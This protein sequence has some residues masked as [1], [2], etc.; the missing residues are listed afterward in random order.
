MRWVGRSVGG[1][2][3]STA[4]RT[5]PLVPSGV[6]RAVIRPPCSSQT[7]RAMARPRPVPPPESSPAP[8]RSKTRSTRSAGMPGPSSRTSSHQVDASAARPVTST[9]PPGGLCRTALST[10]FA[11]SWA[12]RAGSACTVRSVGCASCRTRTG[13]PS[14]EASATAPA[15]RSATRTSE[16][17]RGA[18]PASILDRSSRSVTRA[19]SRSDWCSAPRRAASSGRTTPSTRFSRRARWAASGVRSSCD[20]VATSWR[21]W[22]SAEARSAA[23]ALNARARSPTSSVEVAVT[24]WP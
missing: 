24:R 14:T 4:R 12:S 2:S 5:A 16:T 10:R 1:R 8:N 17:D 15:S 19:L 22:V 7:Q 23:M 6:G 21:R 20:T 11:T 18:T 9:S 3:G 13:R